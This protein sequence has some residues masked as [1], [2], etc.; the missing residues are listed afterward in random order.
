MQLLVVS[1][2]VRRALKVRGKCRFTSTYSSWSASITG[3]ILT[4]KAPH[5]M[6]GVWAPKPVWDLY[7]KKS[8]AIEENRTVNPRSASM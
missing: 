2:A 1:C 4:R 5:V 6:G 7:R 3:H 8:S